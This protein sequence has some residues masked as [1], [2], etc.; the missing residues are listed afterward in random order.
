MMQFDEALKKARTATKKDGRLRF[1]FQT[2]HGWNFGLTK[3][4]NCIAV[5]SYTARYVVDNQ[6]A[7]YIVL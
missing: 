4:D 5:N 6:Y 1:L 3:K 7:D 2:V